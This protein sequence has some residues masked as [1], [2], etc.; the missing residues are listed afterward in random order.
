MRIA[1]S[2]V[3]YH[4][5]MRGSITKIGSPF[6]MPSPSSAFAMRFASRCSSTNEWR[7]RHRAVRVEGQQREIVRLLL[8]APAPDHVRRRS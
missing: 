4:C 8:R 5:G 3:A 1:P 7:A 2:T 6:V